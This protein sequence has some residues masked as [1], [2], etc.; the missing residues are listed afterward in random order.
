MKPI[1]KHSRYEPGTFADDRFSRIYGVGIR[2]EAFIS[3]RLK[4]KVCP[5]ATKAASTA[6]CDNHALNQKHPNHTLHTNGSPVG[7]FKSAAIVSPAQSRMLL[8]QP[9]RL[10]LDPFYC[11]PP[12]PESRG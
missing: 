10:R 11:H 5:F 2:H 3:L 1:W 9:P 6:P 4:V 8:A 12:L 7:S